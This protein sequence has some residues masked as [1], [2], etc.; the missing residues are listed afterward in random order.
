MNLNPKKKGVALLIASL[1]YQGPPT[2]EGEGVAL[3]IDS[4]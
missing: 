2:R 1:R 4:L 3:L